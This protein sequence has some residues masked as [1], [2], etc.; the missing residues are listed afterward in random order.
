MSSAANATVIDSK[1]PTTKQELIATNIKFLIEQLEAGHSGSPQRLPHGHEPFSQ[2]QLWPCLGN[3]TTDA[4]ATRVAGF[5]TWKNLG[6]SVNARAKKKAFASLLRW[7][8][9]RS[10]ERRGSRKGHY[11]AEHPRLCLV[12]VMPMSSIFRRRMV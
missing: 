5:W 12:S 8:G 9:A 11:Q 2:L 1:K 4:N 3:R 7:S 6:R 10:Q